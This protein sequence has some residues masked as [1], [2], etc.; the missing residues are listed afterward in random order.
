MYHPATENMSR[1]IEFKQNTRKKHTH[2]QS[3]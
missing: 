1:K 3:S 2:W